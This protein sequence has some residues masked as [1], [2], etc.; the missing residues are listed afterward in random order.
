MLIVDE[1]IE[2][3]TARV[4]QSQRNAPCEAADVPAAKRSGT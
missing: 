1:R 2:K 3:R 4:P